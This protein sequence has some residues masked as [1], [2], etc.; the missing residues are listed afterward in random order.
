MS[1]LTSYVLSPVSSFL[2]H[3]CFFLIFL[4]NDDWPLGPLPPTEYLL[5]GYF[6]KW[7]ERGSIWYLTLSNLYLWKTSTALTIES[8]Y[9]FP[10]QISCL[11]S[12]YSHS[13]ISKAWISHFHSLQFIPH[14]SLPTHKCQVT[15]QSINYSKLVRNQGMIIIPLNMRN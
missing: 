2:S 7:N 11:Y 3:P 15:I 10:F 4:F 1:L 5:Y 13:Q 6:G 14:Q 9:L 12:Q 8:I